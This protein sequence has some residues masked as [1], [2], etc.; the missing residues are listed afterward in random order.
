MEEAARHYSISTIN[1]TGIKEANIEALTAKAE[2]TLCLLRSCP[3]IVG[4]KRQWR[5]PCTPLG[6]ALSVEASSVHRTLTIVLLLLL[7]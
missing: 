3:L 2:K 7:P 1:G 6:S 5:R 4:D